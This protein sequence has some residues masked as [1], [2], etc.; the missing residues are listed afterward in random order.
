M[1]FVRLEWR[2]SH[3]RWPDSRVITNISTHLH[4]PPKDTGSP[5]KFGMTQQQDGAIIVRVANYSRQSSVFIFLPLL[6]HQ[7][8]LDQPS[9]SMDMDSAVARLASNLGRGDKMNDCIWYWANQSRL[10][11]GFSTF[12]SAYSGLGSLRLHVA[13]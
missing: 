8:T 3:C 7:E 4:I 13:A 6:R 12:I 5:H 11:F 1:Q 9:S 10:Y 2:A